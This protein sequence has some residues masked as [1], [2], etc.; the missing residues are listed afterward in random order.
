MKFDGIV[1]FWIFIY[2]TIHHPI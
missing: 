1:V 2:Y